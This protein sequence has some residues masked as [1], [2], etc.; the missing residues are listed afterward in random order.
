LLAF[1]WLYA[2]TG[3]TEKVA[4]LSQGVFWLVLPSLPLF[5]ILPAL[6]RAGIGFWPSIGTACAI[7]VASYFA[8]I[9][10]LGKLA[11]DT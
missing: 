2:E 8:V 4:A 6:L 3:S 11:I 1:F 10:L 9:W 5:L 7:T